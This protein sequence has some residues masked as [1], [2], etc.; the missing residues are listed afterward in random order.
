M[1]RTKNHKFFD[2]I[3]FS[4]KIH[5]KFATISTKYHL[6]QQHPNEYNNLANT[7]TTKYQL[8]TQYKTLS[9]NMLEAMVA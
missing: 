6:Q 7:D 9:S 8:P 1:V 4:K 3:T 5:N 2:I